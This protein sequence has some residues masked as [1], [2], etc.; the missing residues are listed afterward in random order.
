MNKKTI[1][2]LVERKQLHALDKLSAQ[3]GVPRA[4]YIREAVRD[5]LSKRSVAEPDT[6]LKKYFAYRARGQAEIF[7]SHAPPRDKLP[8]DLSARLC[9]YL[10][11]VMERL[12]TAEVATRIGLNWKHEIVRQAAKLT[13]IANAWPKAENDLAAP[14]G[15]A[16]CTYCGD[17]S[18]IGACTFGRCPIRH[19]KPKRPKKETK[20]RR[21]ARESTR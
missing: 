19:L 12:K 2:T 16:W 4:E 5:L 14:D 11:A 18:V 3:T 10:E 8:D 13:Q 21:R 6:E 20:A 9:K 15:Q 1:F 7:E 17:F